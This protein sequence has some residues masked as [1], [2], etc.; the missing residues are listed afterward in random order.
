M[1]PSRIPTPVAPRRSVDIALAAA[2]LLTCGMALYHFWLPF[3]F[4]WADGLT[5]EPM[6]RW[7]LFMLNAS[8]SYLLLVGGAMTLAIALQRGAAERTDRWVLMGMGGY[9]LFNSVYQVLAP[10]PLPPRLAMLKWVL[11]GFAA[12]VVLL[13]LGAL[14]RSRARR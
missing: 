13:Y 12:T 8:F 10:M 2:G 3:A 11:G 6:L 5:H 4:H 14:A 1:S 9:W 7:A